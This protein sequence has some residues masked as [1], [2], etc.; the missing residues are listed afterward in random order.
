L[1]VVVSDLRDASRSV[2]VQ[3]DELSVGADRVWLFS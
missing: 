1:K 2:I 3:T